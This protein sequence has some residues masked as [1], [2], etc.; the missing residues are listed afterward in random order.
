MRPGAIDD[1]AALPIGK[2]R[3]AELQIEEHPRFQN[4][5]WQVQRTVWTALLFAV[6]AALLGVLGA[7]GPFSVMRSQLAESVVVFP[8]V[9]RNARPE[10]IAITSPVSQITLDRHFLAAFGIEAIT[11]EP[12]LQ[13][14][15]DDGLVLSFAFTGS[16]RIALTVIPESYLRQQVAMQVGSDRHD[17]SPLILP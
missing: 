16:L 5:F 3:H 14:S 13:S 9:M 17:L 8:A 7:G 1:A 4:W 6:I 12:V 15:V 11:P 10:T 2:G